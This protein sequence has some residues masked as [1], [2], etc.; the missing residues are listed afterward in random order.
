ME[1]EGI[2]VYYRRIDR[3]GGGGLNFD[4]SLALQG[5]AGPLGDLKPSSISYVRG[6]ACVFPLEG[7][8]GGEAVDLPRCALR[9]KHPY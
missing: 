6:F 8:T 7:A 3:K 1:A 5:L 9:A 4:L 2:E